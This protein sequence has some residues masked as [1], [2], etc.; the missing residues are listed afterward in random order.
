MCNIFFDRFIIVLIT[1][2]QLAKH[3]ASPGVDQSIGGHTRGVCTSSR[4]HFDL[5]VCK[6]VLSVH[7]QW[8][9]MLSVVVHGIRM[10]HKLTLIVE[11]KCIKIANIGEGERKSR[12]CC[13]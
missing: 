8:H 7:Q 11:A 6:K 12:A 4:H 10:L 2:S 3:C 5:L 1:Y 13:H 9:Y